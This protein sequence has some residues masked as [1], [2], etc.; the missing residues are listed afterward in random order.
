ME[1]TSRSQLARILTEAWIA[2]NG[3]CLACDSDRILQTAVN[4]QARD[5]ECPQCGHPYELK[6]SVRPF[7][8]T[9]VDGAYTSLMRRIETNS[10]PSF[11]LMRYSDT[12]EVT[13]LTAVHRSLITSELI[14]E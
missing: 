7:G 10:V 12:S 1:Y 13:D 8:K 2:S 11:L 4:T 6:S 3:Y 5:F 9:I 14:H